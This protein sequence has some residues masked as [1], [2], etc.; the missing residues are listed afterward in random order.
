[1]VASITGCVGTLCIGGYN[2][3]DVLHPESLSDIDFGRQPNDLPGFAYSTQQKRA[4]AT[5]CVCPG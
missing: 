4:S 1:M 5:C 2:H 3:A